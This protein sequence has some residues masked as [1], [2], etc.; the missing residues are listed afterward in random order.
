MGKS[1]FLFYFIFVGSLYQALACSCTEW[2]GKQSASAVFA[3]KV[4]AM[5]KFKNGYQ[6]KFKPDTVFKGNLR[7][8]IIIVKTA[9]LPSCGFGFKV[10]ARYVVY[11]RRRSGRAVVV[12]QC[13]RTKQLSSAVKSKD[14]VLEDDKSLIN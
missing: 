2:V 13:S 8:G 9:L 1:V 3:G 10:G 7:T 5:R 6:V 14:I 4:V 12:S 11:G